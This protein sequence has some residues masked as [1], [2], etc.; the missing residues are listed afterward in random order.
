MELDKTDDQT[1]LRSLL[2]QISQK[3]QQGGL[4]TTGGPAAEGAAATLLNINGKAYE[5]F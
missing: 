4:V 3:G 2:K 1:C 5:F